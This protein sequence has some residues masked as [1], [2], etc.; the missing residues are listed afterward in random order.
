MDKRVRID[1][2]SLLNVSSMMEALSDE[3]ITGMRENTW[4]IG[5][6]IRNGDFIRD[7]LSQCS[8]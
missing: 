7:T 3:Q 1:V 8:A 6:K 4:S 2:D 5:C